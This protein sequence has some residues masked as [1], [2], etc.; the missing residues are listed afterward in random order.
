M[1]R[2][3]NLKT[4]AMFLMAASL[5]TF[6][7]CKDYDDDINNLQGQIN[8]IK[9]TMKTDL[10][11]LTTKV[12]KA[13]KDAVKDLEAKIAKA[14]TAADAAKALAAKGASPEDVKAAEKKAKEAAKAVEDAKKVADAAKAQADALKKEIA[15]LKKKVKDLEAKG[16]NNTGNTGNADVDAL[17][18]EIADLKKKV[19]E[20]VKGMAKVDGTTVLRSLVL[21]P[22]YVSKDGALPIV[23][24]ATMTT[25]G[26][27]KVSL[28]T[29]EV[30]YVMNPKNFDI[31]NIEKITFR[32]NS[33]AT[34][35]AAKEDEEV[36]NY[37]IDQETGDLLVTVELDVTKFKK[38]EQVPNSPVTKTYLH[39]FMTQ[40]V[41]T[42]GTVVSSD[43]ARVEN[44]EK[45]VDLAYIKADKTK[46]KVVVKKDVATAKA[47]GNN[48]IVEFVLEMKDGKAVA[49]DLTT[50]FMGLVATADAKT[51]LAKYGYTDVKITVDEYRK[52]PEENA[53]EEQKK[54][55]E[56][57]YNV[58]E[59][60][61]EK[62]DQNKFIKFVDGK[63]VA[64]VYDKDGNIASLDKTPIVRVVLR[65]K[66]AD[67]T[68]CVVKA[69]FVKLMIVKTPTTT[70]PTNNPDPTVIQF[71]DKTPVVLSCAGDKVI[72]VG[73]EKMNEDFYHDVQ[74][75]TGL[76]KVD[77][78]NTYELKN[79]T[80]DL[81]AA[82][83]LYG[84]IVELDDPSAQGTKNLQY[85]V[86]AAA[87]KKALGTEN[88]VTI[89]REVSYVLK[90]N[91]TQN[92]KLEEFKM[93]FYVTVK[94]EALTGTDAVSALDGGLFEGDVTRINYP[95]E[96]QGNPNTPQFDRNLDQLFPT[97]ASQLGND[98]E[99]S[100]VFAEK[101]QFNGFTVTDTSV[102]KNGKVVAT[103]NGTVLSL[104]NNDVAKQLLNTD[105]MKVRVQIK[106]QRKCTDG[107]L[108]VIFEE[109]VLKSDKFTVEYIKPL[110]IKPNPSAK[111]FD[112]EFGNKDYHFNKSFEI[113]DWRNV[114]VKQGTSL[115][116]HYGITG[117]KPL[118]DEATLNTGN[119]DTPYL[120]GGKVIGTYKELTAIKGEL[121]KV[122]P[123]SGPTLDPVINY[124]N[125]GITL[126]QDV[127]IYIPVEI[128]YTWG[129]IKSKEMVKVIIKKTKN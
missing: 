65:A 9:A 111:V 70:P 66:K 19:D 33:P 39:T 29:T 88:E 74:A 108:D 3:L 69:G 72:K 28:T 125:I 114:E 117:I 83:P 102:S 81:T 61:A 48:D 30:R 15:D 32:Q 27:G 51:E 41:L 76:S 40:V 87:M 12:D 49:K 122:R 78:H 84:T 17:K 113:F 58:K 129:T 112:E 8:D 92:G 68:D 37:R 18:K 91:V 71:V 1:R 80:E 23:D 105:Q 104:Q 128:T 110:H 60:T 55:L 100:Y 90:S 6:T 107:N 36:K 50:E 13:V 57:V 121:L 44:S 101:G 119:G 95:V 93:E 86:G 73:T 11:A 123:Q 79:A 22:D 25:D 98:Y 24:F 118:L 127:A 20:A 2:F 10:D 99:Y 34:K 52:D 38:D 126:T 7:G 109:G 16:N 62:T 94:R 53:T 77:F 26:C 85:T 14:Q 115:F 96:E 64:T 31:K 56:I 120:I 124:S 35:A 5:L 42:D 46:D 45:K 75:A 82:K 21:V 47:E 59:G 67:G 116:T 63:A 43:W 106:V 4:F 89:K 103:I 54:A 97:L